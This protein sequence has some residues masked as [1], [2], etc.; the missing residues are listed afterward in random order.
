[1]LLGMSDH[2]DSSPCVR[3]CCL[4]RNDVCVGCFRT[5]AEILAWGGSANDEERQLI[6]L[7]AI[8]RRESAA[9]RQ[10]TPHA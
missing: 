9:A 7:A 5:L 1:M 2:P 3:R 8:E 10:G 6:R 4:D